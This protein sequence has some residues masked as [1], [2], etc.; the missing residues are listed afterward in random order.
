MAETAE[1]AETAEMAETAREPAPHPEAPEILK[2]QGVAE[3]HPTL[4]ALERF[5]LG[6]L[7]APELQ[8]VLRHLL[9]RCPRCQQLT[10]PLWL[11]GEADD[12]AWGH[13][14]AEGSAARRGAAA[15]PTG[16]MEATT[17]T[18]ELPSNSLAPLNV[19]N[20]SVQNVQHI[21]NSEKPEKPESLE[22]DEYDDV[23]DRVFQR[24]VAKEAEI[25]RERE[26]S[27]ELYQNLVH[28]LPAR[29]RLLVGNSS[30]YRSRMLCER[31]LAESHEAGFQ[32]PARAIELARLALVIADLLPPQ[33]SIGPEVPPDRGNSLGR[34]LADGLRA[35]AWSQLGNALRIGS[36]HAGAEQAFA[37]AE[38]LLDA[39]CRIGLLDR[40]R[41]LDQKAS[42]LRDQR[43]FV[44]A[45]QLLD[46]VMA[47]YQNLG[48]WHLLGRT[49]N[50]KA[51]V[52]GEAGEVEEEMALLR[53]ALDLL[54]PHDDPRMFLTV[55]HNLIV[56]LNESG[57]S[58]DAFALLFHTRPLYLKMGDRMNLLRLR[59]VEGQVALGLRRAE[60]AELAFL[61]VRDVF[62]E[63]GLD[64]D[65]ALASLDLA[66]AYAL[67]G[68]SQEIRRMAAE[69]LAV[70][71]SRK[72]HREAMAALLIFCRAA[73]RDQ[74]GIA[75]VQEVSGFMKRARNHPDLLFALP[76]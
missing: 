70:F 41:V 4:E 30:R 51:T 2:T 73:Q 9:T 34:E 29:Q 67:Q 24:V 14:R 6:E 61:E 13:H 66:M 43:R 57:S 18:P 37:R 62:L 25:C 23:F 1:T 5:M 44:E 28:H 55:R 8:E 68:R 47:V 22:N 54:D 7:A 39:G 3:P 15:M 27:R 56:A 31:L 19:Q 36:D 11:P 21:E 75:L 32:D 42:F 74:A 20:Q 45:S 52:T 59:W 49:L 63:M 12:P 26:Q 16:A 72:I 53:R 65:A 17:G 48:Q 71:E 69:M 46:Q 60:Q 40:A 33:V 64:Y 10:D 38:A 50:Q 76:E 35:R 58:R